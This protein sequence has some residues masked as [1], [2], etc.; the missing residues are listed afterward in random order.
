MLALRYRWQWIAVNTLLIAIVTILT[1]VP[2]ILMPQQVN[3][4]PGVDKWLHALT[5]AILALWFT[6][7]YARRSYWL[8]A[9]GLAGYGA[10]IEIGQSLI[11][12]RSAEWGDLVA[13]VAG[14]AVGLVIALL[15]TGGWS[16]RAEQWFVD[17]FG[18]SI[19]KQ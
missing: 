4:L 2:A 1:I 18:G 5:F 17:R 9:I 15:V 19:R 13:D 14:I 6:G 11:P 12:Y 8:I 10:L 16:L 3:E 7:Q